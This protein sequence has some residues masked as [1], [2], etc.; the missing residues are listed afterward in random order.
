MKTKK[1]GNFF[2][3]RRT[4]GALAGS[5]LLT[6]VLAASPE[7]RA[8]GGSWEAVGSGQY[9]SDTS[10]GYPSLAF[11][12]S[13]HDLYVAAVEE[14][15]SI[16][17]KH[18]DGTSWENVGSAMTSNELDEAKI[19]FNPSTEEPYLA[20]WD[21]TLG[22]IVVKKYDGSSW[23]DVGSHGVTEN[24]S[25][26]PSLAFNP[27]TGNPYIAYRDHGIS[28]LVV[29]MY[30]GSAWENVGPF[31]I[32]GGDTYYISLAFN[33]STH[34]PYVAFD[35][36]GSGDKLR[37]MKYDG[38]SWTDVGSSGVSS[39][40]ASFVDLAFNEETNL[41]YVIYTEPGNALAVKRFDGSSWQDM[42]SPMGSDSS[43]RRGQI[44]FCPSTNVPYISYANDNSA[45]NIVVRK[46]SGSGWELVGE[47]GFNSYE[48]YGYELGFSPATNEPFLVF[49]DESPS[50]IV[51]H[52]L[53]IFKFNKA[54]SSSPSVSYSGKKSSRKNITFTFQD[55]KITTKKSWVKVWLGGKKVKVRSVKRSGNN[56]KVGL[57]VKYGKWAAGSYNL[58]M[59]FKKKV[60]RTKHTDTWRSLSALTIL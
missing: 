6:L 16:Q 57:Q 18:F 29:K 42:G 13:S 47:S 23:A 2:S 56:L 25:S 28:K 19:A 36:V 60:G 48:G 7:A 21:I 37:V 11:H 17:V 39:G 49:E 30:N 41:P 58:R 34:E 12:P 3:P 55:L 44:A 4:A 22:K 24:N 10:H 5:V 43:A 1:P 14:A 35:D 31:G 52:H 51:F 15:N 53:G 20:Y 33:P 26:S 40:A 46:Y 8:A 54:V 27:A 45:N 59:V 38:S 9:L 32:S 50:D